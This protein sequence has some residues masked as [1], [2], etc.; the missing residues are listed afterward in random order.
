MIRIHVWVS[1]NIRLGN[2]NA[3]TSYSTQCTTLCALCAVACIGAESNGVWAHTALKTLLQIHTRVTVSYW[4]HR[5]HSKCCTC[6]AFECMFMLPAAIVG[7]CMHMHTH[8]H[9]HALSRIHA[10]KHICGSQFVSMAVGCSVTHRRMRMY[11]NSGTAALSVYVWVDIFR[12]S[13]FPTFT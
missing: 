2:K 12:R 8:K 13:F 4:V 10:Y 5:P 9:M 7:C 11:S 6:S 3:S 1:V